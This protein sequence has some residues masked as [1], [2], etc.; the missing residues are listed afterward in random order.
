MECGVETKICKQIAQLVDGYHSTVS[1]QLELLASKQEAMLLR[2]Q[3]ILDHEQDTE[4]MPAWDVAHLAP[5][6]NPPS[7]P[8]TQSTRADS[9]ILRGESYSS[10]ELLSADFLRQASPDGA[11]LLKDLHS[12]SQRAKGPEQDPGAE[13]QIVNSNETSGQENQRDS[14]RLR[15]R[16]LKPS[17]TEAELNR[18]FHADDEQSLDTNRWQN[19][20]RNFQ[21]KRPSIHQS[22][23]SVRLWSFGK[24][25]GDIREQGFLTLFRSAVRVI[26]GSP[27][28][29]VC[30]GI[31]ILGNAVVM[32]LETDLVAKTGRAADIYISLGLAFNLWYVFELMLRFIASGWDL[33]F[34]KDWRWGW[35][36]LVLLLTSLLDMIAESAQLSSLAA[37]RTVR[38]MRLFRVARVLR[39]VRMLRYVREFRKIVFSLATSLQT[40]FW[41]MMLMVFVM[42]C[43]GVFF[44]QCASDYLRLKPNMHQDEADLKE[45]FGSLLR[46]MYSLYLA[47]TAGRGWGELSSLLEGV[48]PIV[49]AIFIVY[50]SVCIFGLMNVVTAVFVESAMASSQ[51]YKDLLVQEKMLMDQTRVRHMKE[52]FRAI[53]IDASGSVSLEEMQ[54]FVQNPELDLQSYF[55]ALD[56]NATDTQTLFKMLDHDQSGEVDIDEFCDGCMRLRGMARSFDLHTMRYEEQRH[57]KRMIKFMQH[58]MRNL[59]KLGDRSHGVAEDLEDMHKRMEQVERGVGRLLGLCERLGPMPPMVAPPSARPGGAAL[60]EVVPPSK[61]LASAATRGIGAGPVDPGGG[62][63]QRWVEVGRCFNKPPRPLPPPPGSGAT[64]E[65]SS[66]EVEKRSEWPP[67]W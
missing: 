52:I 61:P 40:L 15:M 23:R 26:V 43:F 21:P 38:T 6:V 39:V 2:M 47:I 63:S 42:F 25:V 65:D 49:M 10:S 41:S 36:D 32:G 35:F 30:S 19:S 53:D 22:V 48:D 4:R 16:Y 46:S 54:A 45:S 28:F 55:E 18:S 37:G 66:D 9:P 13:M 14:S 51:H 17:C 67:N 57:Q 50:V 59:R 1:R 31:I 5:N 29:D 8:T 27:Y 7:N 56:I 11:D 60:S 12:E 62:E 33:F 64:S 34:G 20:A 58:V 3:S 44:T 24:L